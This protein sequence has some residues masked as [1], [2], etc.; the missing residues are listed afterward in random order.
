MKLLLMKPIPDAPPVQ[1][2]VENL[3]AKVCGP[4]CHAEVILDDG[5]SYSSV[6]G[7][8]GVRFLSAEDI[9]SELARHADYWTV[10]PLPWATTDR[11]YQF[12]EQENGARYD[13]RGALSAG[14]G[15]AMQDPDKWFCSEI[16]GRV[17]SIVSG[18]HIPDLLCPTSLGTWIEGILDGETDDSLET[19][20][21]VQRVKRLTKSI[22][23]TMEE[24]NYLGDLLGNQITMSV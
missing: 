17:I 19:Y 24:K 18:I 15:L 10:V 23:L 6:A 16:S 4:Y 5:R 12:C 11:A 14:F 21:R 8:R 1:R 22:D 2:I 7:E 9:N 13:Y 20:E 3:I